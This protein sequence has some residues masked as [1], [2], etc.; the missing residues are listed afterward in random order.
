VTAQPDSAGAP[1][2]RMR[3]IVVAYGALIANDAID[4][5]VRRGE[6]HA[7]LG[8]NGA[9]K[10]T[11]MKA[12]VG[13]APMKHGDI[14]FNGKTIPAGSPSEARAAGIGMV[15]QHFMLIPTL[16]V[17]QNVCIGLRS[18]SAA[19]IRGSLFP[20]YRKVAERLASLSRQFRLEMNPSALV[21]D[22]SVGEQQRVEILRT[23]FRGAR[24]LVLD[25]PTSVLIPRE[26]DGLFDI[27]RTLSSQGTAIIFISHK[28][29]EVMAIS[30][31]VTIL[32][33][34]KVVATRAAADTNPRELARLMVGRDMAGLPS[35]E[36]VAA[37]A[38]TVLRTEDLRFA[39]AR[40]VKKLQGIDLDIRAGE[41]H[42][43]AGVDGNGQ[44]EL[45][46]IIAGILSPS[47]GKL[48]L[49]G[50]DITRQSPQKRIRAG[51]AYVPGDRQRTGLAMEL[52]VSDNLMLKASDMPPFA[53]GGFLHFGRIAEMVD[54]SI[55]AYDVRCTS[56]AQ[57]V[58]TLSGGNQ[59]K[60]VLA[61][62]L[63][64]APRL[65]VAE[66]PTHGLDVGAT[67][68]VHSMLLEQ[69]RRG[70]AILLISTELDEVLSLS[71][72][73]SVLYEGRLMGTF[74]HDH[75]D[76]ESVGLL[77]AGRRE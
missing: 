30:Q 45:A 41:I 3:G 62:E 69:R 35:V 24:L 10:T 55:R 17:A 14:V 74:D 64:A 8:E 70:C 77:M 72:R 59:Q 56:S 43:I 7:L 38:P 26:I 67:H 32:R 11:L 57:E 50:R 40:G 33:Q 60:L 76:R 18:A 44:V 1:L 48:W 25:E 63:R 68:Y 2:L 51:L 66:Q 28:L 19:G 37:G 9:G 73:V 52:S 27:I 54:A 29:N 13:L 47:S 23:L 36:A 49:E 53:R 46:R 4:L 15:H 71:N 16:T 42:G 75:A 12:L 58:R 61:R 20:D 6:I 39:D 65:I 34:G 22:L 5:D 31:N 21:A